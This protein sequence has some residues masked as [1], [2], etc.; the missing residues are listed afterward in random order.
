MAHEENR[1]QR[2][3]FFVCRT[4]PCGYLL[5][6][7][8]LHQL[9]WQQT[10][11][12]IGLCE[13]RVVEGMP[14]KISSPRWPTEENHKVLFFLYRTQTYGYQLYSISLHRQRRQQTI[15]LMGLCETRVVEGMPEKIS[16]P[17]W[18]T[19]KKE[20]K[21]LII[22]CLTSLLFIHSDDWRCDVFSEIIAFFTFF[23]GFVSYC[24]H[25]QKCSKSL[26][27]KVFRSLLWNRESMQLLYERR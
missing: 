11:E 13:T 24:K 4:C 2:F 3:S 14:E 12:S 15:K 20:V 16:S 5:R 1:F 10:T 7:I 9:R 18:P 17:R 26:F 8:S 22:R 21:Y 27:R 19:K 23:E 25:G 6:S